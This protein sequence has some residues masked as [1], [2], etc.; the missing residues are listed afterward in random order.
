MLLSHDCFLHWEILAPPFT[1]N[2]SLL[3]SVQI[4]NMQAS[5]NKFIARS[6]FNFMTRRIKLMILQKNH[7][8]LF[9]TDHRHVLHCVTI[10]SIHAKRHVTLGITSVNFQNHTKISGLENILNLQ[11]SIY[12]VLCVN[13]CFISSYVKFNHNSIIN[14]L[15]SR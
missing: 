6:I 7:T 4:R 2:V 15:C 10:Y 11:M 3:T 14:D 1:K 12:S 13:H 8:F 9:L 5:N